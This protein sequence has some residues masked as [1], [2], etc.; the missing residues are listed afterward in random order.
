MQ[1][2][3]ER[4]RLAQLEGVPPFVIFS[5]ST[6][7]EMATYF[8]DTPE[9]MAGITGIGDAKL[10][11]YGDN[12]MTIIEMYK[13]VHPEEAQQRSILQVPITI[14]NSCKKK[15]GQTV[16]ETLKLAR[17]GLSLDAI[18]Q[19]RGLSDGTISQHIEKLLTDGQGEGLDMDKL[20][21][22]AKRIQIEELF[23]RTAAGT[24]KAIL[25]ASG[26]TVTYAEIRVVRAFMQ[27]E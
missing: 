20:L 19:I 9:Q 2:R 22:P 11:K 23:I 17:Q 15:S 8:P 14:K 26:N 1:L 10:G 6:L 24:L 13:F 25:E 4:Q 7:R 5:D 16:Q 18:A 3:T 21:D 12:F 27:A